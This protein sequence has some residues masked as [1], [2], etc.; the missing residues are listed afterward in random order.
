MLLLEF[1]L[2]S[3]VNLVLLIGGKGLDRA[4]AVRRIAA[5]RRGEPV[6]LRCQYR[7]GT[8][9]L[10]MR[11]GRVTL[12]RSGANVG[13]T[14]ARVVRLAG[15]SLAVTVHGRGGTSLKCCTVGGERAELQILTWNSTMIALINEVIATRP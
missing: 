9:T 11:P 12:R 14:G 1:A 6:T 7:T 15:P 5:F 4:L 13:S 8:R 3:L 2:H 10:G